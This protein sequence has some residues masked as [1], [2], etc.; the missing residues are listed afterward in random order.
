MA[1]TEQQNELCGQM[2]AQLESVMAE[3][4]RIEHEQWADYVFAE[5]MRKVEA[6][7]RA[8]EVMQVCEV[9][10][11]QEVREECSR[12]GGGEPSYAP[13]GGGDQHAAGYGALLLCSSLVLF[14]CPAGSKAAPRECV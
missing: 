2:T 4:E 1:E 11:Q 14:S 10:R 8:V 7:V 6:D 13:C 3:T 5:D 9:V 12:R